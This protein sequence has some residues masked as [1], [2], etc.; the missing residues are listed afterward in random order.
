[1]SDPDEQSIHLAKTSPE[2][3]RSGCE[4]SI[5]LLRD[6][7]YR[8]KQLNNIDHQMILKY[9]LDLYKLQYNKTQH[10]KT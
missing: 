5:D 3:I 4:D 10:G 6:C 2:S 1:M 7:V 9:F 8:K